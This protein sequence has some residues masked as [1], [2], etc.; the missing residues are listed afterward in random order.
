[1]YLFIT[2]AT[3]SLYLDKISDNGRMINNFFSKRRSL[4]FKNK[5][6]ITKSFARVVKC[7]SDDSDFVKLNGLSSKE[8]AHLDFR[9]KI[10]WN[11]GVH[12]TKVYS[13]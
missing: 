1:M 12:C 9:T 6:T 5:N 10:V 13:P 7:I 4:Q 8:T 11:F 2:L 3:H